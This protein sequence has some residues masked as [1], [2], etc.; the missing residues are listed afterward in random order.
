[1]G[2]SRDKEPYEE[3][4]ARE[5]R[6][7]KDGAGCVG[8]HAGGAVQMAEMD[9]TQTSLRSGAA[10]YTHTHTLLLSEMTGV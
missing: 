2:I 4:E 1:M 9:A 10:V 7:A 8:T 3:W 6:H 5:R